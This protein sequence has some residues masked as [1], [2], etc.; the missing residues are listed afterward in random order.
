MAGKKKTT[1]AKMNREQKLRQRQ[2]E[3]EMKRQER[4]NAPS[5][6]DTIGQPHAHVDLTAD[7][8]VDAD[9]RVVPIEQP[10]V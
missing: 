5:D 10:V 3:K 9:G 1:F 7:V 2:A 4:K 8:Y 6:T